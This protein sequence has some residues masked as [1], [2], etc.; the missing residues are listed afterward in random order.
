MILGGTH[1]FK[2]PE[3]VSDFLPLKRGSDFFAF[4]VGGQIFSA[5]SGEGV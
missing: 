5:S 3:G 4:E 2:G 1:F